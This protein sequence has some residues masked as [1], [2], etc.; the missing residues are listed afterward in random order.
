MSGEWTCAEV[1]LT[2]SLGYGTYSFVVRDTSQLEPAAALAM[3]TYD[4]AGSGPNNREMGI[5]ISSWGERGTENGQFVVQPF[6]V[7]ENTSRFLV[8]SGVLTHSFQ[9]APRSVTFNTA[10]GSAPG[11]KATALA[12][13][14]FTSGVP[15]HGTESIRMSF[16]VFRAT[17]QVLTHDN[18]VVVEKFEYLP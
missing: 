2:R 9:W 8:P 7:P 1:S 4:Y 11:D 18:E 17:K 15:T 13:H 16:Y 3:F 12:Q 5:E 6:Y 14:E 10:R